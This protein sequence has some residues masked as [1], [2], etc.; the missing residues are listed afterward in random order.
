MGLRNLAA[1]LAA[2]AVLVLAGCECSKVSQSIYITNPDA[3]TQALIDNCSAHVPAAGESCMPTSEN[4]YPAYD[5]GCLPL[6]RRV[7]EIA[8]QFKGWFIEECHVSISQDAGGGAT[9][10]VTYRPSTCG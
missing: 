3:D 10:M 1:A 8:D 6:C 4:P 7:L 5:C 9:V 2:S